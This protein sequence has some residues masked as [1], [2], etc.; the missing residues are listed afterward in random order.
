MVAFAPVTWRAD[1]WE[2][3]PR[4]RV[5]HSERFNEERQ[6]ALVAISA[7][8]DIGLT[9]DRAEAIACSPLFDQHAK[10]G[11]NFSD[12]VVVAD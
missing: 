10:L 2:F 12:K 7:F 1:A 8:A 11:G 6:K 3:A 4:T 5:L 9:S